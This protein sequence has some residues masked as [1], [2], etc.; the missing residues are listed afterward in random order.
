MINE[1]VLKHLRKDLIMKKLIDS[2]ELTPWRNS[3]DLFLDLANVII[4]QQL[5]ER[6]GDTIF[7]RFKQTFNG[8][9][10]TPK[11]VL[12]IPDEKIRQTGISRMKVSYIKNVAKAIV[13]KEISLEQLITSSDEQVVE[14][15]TKIKGIGRWSA[16]MILMFS[17]QRM[18]VFSVSDLGLCTAIARLYGVDKK[19]KKKI[20]K[21]ALCWRP[22][23]TIACRYLWKFLE[24]KADW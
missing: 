12:K 24:N 4:S 20:E 8:E 17:L 18:D 3:G 9:K 21:I 6:V 15:L 22:Y 14:L 11:N 1:K 13:N 7:V 5:S 16:E 10:I 2:L 19:D 23:R